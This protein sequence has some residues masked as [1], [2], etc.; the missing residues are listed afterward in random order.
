MRL[1]AQRSCTQSGNAAILVMR[2]SAFFMH[3]GGAGG[4]G[5]PLVFIRCLQVH[6]RCGG[7]VLLCFFVMAKLRQD[8]LHPYTCELSACQSE[9]NTNT[10][11]SS[12]LWCFLGCAGLS[13]RRDHSNACAC[14]GSTLP[15][16]G[17]VNSFL[18]LLLE[19][20]VEV[21]H[22]QASCGL[23]IPMRLQAQRSCTQW[24]N[25]AVLVM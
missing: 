7:W 18:E 2:F 15:I 10:V 5:H 21:L 19:L 25:A 17:T 4:A 23:C 20:R 13:L 11:S 14:R 16:R 1:Q 9:G 3:S 8:R 22:P 6:I 24:G 12:V